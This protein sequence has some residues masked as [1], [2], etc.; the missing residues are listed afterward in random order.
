MR[1]LADDRMGR[2]NALPLFWPTEGVSRFRVR[3]C[4]AACASPRRSA[5][6]CAERRLISPHDAELRRADR[7]APR[8]AQLGSSAGESGPCL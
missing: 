6:V 5:R 4:S 7:R 3:R 2:P 1:L 8:A